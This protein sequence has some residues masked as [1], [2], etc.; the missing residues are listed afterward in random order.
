MKSSTLN[1]PQLTAQYTSSTISFASTCLLA[2]GGRAP[3]LG[4]LRLAAAGRTIWA[5]DRGLASLKE[6]DLLPARII[7]DGDSAPQDAWEW[8]ERFAVPIDRFPPEKDWT[9]T[10]L[11]LRKAADSGFSAAL[12]TGAFGGR[13]DHAFSTVFTAA[14]ASIRCVLADE[15]E[16]MLFLKDGERILF[17]CHNTPLA[18]SLLPVSERV[19]GVCAENLHWPLQKS[20]LAQQEPA[21][22]SNVLHGASRSFSVS[23][24]RGLL[25]LYFCCAEQSPNCL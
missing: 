4:W 3:A 23:I 8:G 16:T 21:A 19:S 7:G 14:H 6:A 11:A 2:I 9:D 10:Q 22:I 17:T 18:V 15:R 25:A 24:E 20:V 12:L 5:V 1:L 13:F